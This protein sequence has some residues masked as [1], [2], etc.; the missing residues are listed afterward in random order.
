MRL[1]DLMVCWS[2]LLLGYMIG[3]VIGAVVLPGLAIGTALTV[4]AFLEGPLL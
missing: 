3:G 1:G 4:S 2:L